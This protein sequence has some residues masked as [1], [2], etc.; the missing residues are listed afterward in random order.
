V[1]YILRKPEVVIKR[2]ST[3]Y[4]EQRSTWRET[5]HVN[6]HQYKRKWPPL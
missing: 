5:L 1:T 6:W 3:V 4:W 2:N